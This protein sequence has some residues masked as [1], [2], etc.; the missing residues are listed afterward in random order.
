[1]SKFLA[2][3]L[4]SLSLLPGC[5][6]GVLAAG[7][8]YAVSSSKSSDAEM[9]KAEAD[10]QKGYTDYKLGM[11]RINIDRE[12]NKLQPQPIMTMGEW[13]NTQALP[14]NVRKD[15]AEKKVISQQEAKPE[16]QT[17][18]DSQNKLE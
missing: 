5:G 14:E 16:T 9:A 15:L 7:I 18:K 13:L 3:L 12:K 6:L 17:P 11:E 8:G 1:M 2:V 10:L 4:V